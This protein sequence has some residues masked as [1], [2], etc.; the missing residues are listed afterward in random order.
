MGEFS[1]EIE[2]TWGSASSWL[3]SSEDAAFAPPFQPAPS[4]TLNINPEQ[5]IG[6]QFAFTV[7]IENAGDQTGYGPIIDMVFP[8]TGADGYDGI[9][10]ISASIFGTD[11]PDVGGIFPAPDPADPVCFPLGLGRIEHPFYV[12]GVGDP[13]VVCG[14]E[15]DRLVILE[16][17]FGSITPGYP[18]LE[19]DVIA[20]LSELADL[21]DPA[22][23]ETLLN[24]LTRGGF[25]LGAN[26]LYD[27][28]CC[29]PPVI[30]ESGDST[31]WPGSPV[32][33]SLITISKQYIGPENE[34]A[35]GPNY[36]RSYT[37]SVGIADNQVINDL[38]I[39]DAL[40]PNMQ[41]EP[42]AP[43]PNEVSISPGTCSIYTIPTRAEN[44]P[45]TPGAQNPPDNDLVI[46]CSSVT[47]SGGANEC[48][49]HL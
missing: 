47:G 12:D 7:S 5:L 32:Y 11:I 18:A 42:I 48:A 37:V 34:T 26:P 21:Y 24:I 29:D 4:V 25:W 27:P 39:V 6:S 40:P 22:V 38:L 15:G 8:L 23:P 33:P 41:F 20:E 19:V 9:E 30:S 35:T 17:P 43:N 28:L 13:E 3:A 14:E 1:P 49:D 44:L 31:G 36:I 10:F 45:T 2:K 16:L 46:Y